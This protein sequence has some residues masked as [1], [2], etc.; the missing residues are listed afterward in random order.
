MKRQHLLAVLAAAAL[1]AC[2]A[3]NGT[4]IEITGN[5]IASDE[6][7][8]E[9][10]SGGKVSLGNGVYDPAA[11]GAYLLGLY[12]QNNLVDPNTVA[13]GSI[14]QAKGWRPEHVRIRVN[15][16]EYVDLY[17][18][19][20][21]LATIPAAESRLPVAP[22]STIE[23]EGG[24]GVYILS[25]VTDGLAV[26]LQSST[27]AGETVVLG[28]TLEGKT[29]DGARLDTNEWPFALLIQPGAIVTPT[30]TSPAVASSPCQGQQVA[31]VCK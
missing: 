20:P 15:P 4:S 7:T 12:V 8:C 28:I 26:A 18:P 23:P 19:S 27:G 2:K 25:I 5:A 9:F 17:Q 1:M 3:E 30:C 22:S 21:A 31:S 10:A 11:G 16:P 14:T 13:P 6:K 29:N 24:Q